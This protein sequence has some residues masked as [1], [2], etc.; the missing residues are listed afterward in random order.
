[1]ARCLIQHFV[2]TMLVTCGHQDHG[3]YR[4]YS[5]HRSL[6]KLLVVLTL[7]NSA[8]KAATCADYVA[9]NPGAFKDVYW[10]I[11][12]IKVYQL[13]VQNAPSS[14][15]RL[16]SVTPLGSTSSISAVPVAMGRTSTHSGRS[17]QT[18]SNGDSALTTSIYHNSSR[19]LDALPGTFHTMST[20]ANLSTNSTFRIQGVQA[21]IAIGTTLSSRASTAASSAAS[22]AFPVTKEHV[23]ELISSSL[24]S[25]LT[26]GTDE[27]SKFT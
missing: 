19:F 23:L 17:S 22:T 11:N 25:S 2:V 27:E 7:C 24:T 15:L 18:A 13:P 5:L 16:S 10:S 26:A 12:S 9:N 3:Q 21:S 1:M 14:S 6:Q 4:G 20:S 8:K